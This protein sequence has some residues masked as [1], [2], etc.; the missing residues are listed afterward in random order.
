M[1]NCCCYCD[2][3]LFDLINEQPECDL[4]YDKFLKVKVSGIDVAES[5]FHDTWGFWFVIDKSGI[6]TLDHDVIAEFWVVGGCDGEGGI[7]NGNELIDGTAGNIKV[8][9]GT[10]TSY[11]GKGGDGGYVYH[12]GGITVPKGEGFTTVIADVNDKTGTSVNAAG[13]TFKCNQQ[14]STSTTGGDGGSIPLPPT[15]KSYA[16]QSAAILPK[17]GTDGINTPYGYVGSSGGGGAVCNGQANAENGVKGGIGAGNGNKHWDSGSDAENYGCG[18]GG[19]ATC[20]YV[21]KGQ[22]GGKG[23]KGCV[24]VAYRAKQ[25]YCDEKNI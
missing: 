21:A 13:M 10:D 14:N 23:K 1:G 20:G 25:N 15:G 4:E 3:G 17:R 12:S 22:S 6:F 18:G 19:G 24:I 7:W 9:S 5:G 8:D 2:S 16:F 11:S